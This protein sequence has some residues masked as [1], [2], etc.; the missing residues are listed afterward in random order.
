MGG[1]W[2]WQNNHNAPS[3]SSGTLTLS[4]TNTFTGTTGIINGYTLILAN[5]NALQNSTYQ[6]GEYNTDGGGNLVFDSSVSSHAFTFGGLELMTTY[7][8]YRFPA[9]TISP[10]RTTAGIPSP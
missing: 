7:G 5:T 10:L 8:G 9:P 3:T 1:P 2:D 4:G 6:G